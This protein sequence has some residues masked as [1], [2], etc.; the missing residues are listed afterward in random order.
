MSLHPIVEKILELRGIDDAARDEFL[1]PTLDKLA[2][3]EELPGIDR[4][5]DIILVSRGIV[6]AAQG[7]DLFYNGVESH[8]KCNVGI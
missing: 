5:A 3:P 7:Q 4:A 8:G 6:D 2:K 1:H